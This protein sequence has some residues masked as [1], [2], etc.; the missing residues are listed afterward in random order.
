MSVKLPGAAL[1]PE[2]GGSRKCQ[3]KA[4]A[5]LG[6]AA[7]GVPRVITDGSPWEMQQEQWQLSLHPA[8]GTQDDQGWTQNSR[9]LPGRAQLTSRPLRQD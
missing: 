3:L 6:S 9:L 1:V 8:P 2:E 4:Q 5:Q 7:W